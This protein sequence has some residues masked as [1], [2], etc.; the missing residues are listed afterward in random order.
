[1]SSGVYIHCVRISRAIYMI[2][3]RRG[4]RVACSDERAIPE[5][6][7]TEQQDCSPAFCIFMPIFWNIKI[8]WNSKAVYNN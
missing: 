8:I 2:Y 4:L 3:I 1:M 5:P 7:E 6:K